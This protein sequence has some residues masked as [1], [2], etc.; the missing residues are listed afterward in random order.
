MLIAIVTFVDLAYQTVPLTTA[1]TVTEQSTVELVS[2]SP[3][4]EVQILTYTNTELGT[5][6]YVPPQLCFNQSSCYPTGPTVTALVTNML[7]YDSTI[8]IQETKTF[9]SSVIATISATENSTSLAP[10]YSTLGLGHAA[11]GALAVTVI[12]ILILLI[13][14]TGVR[15][16]FHKP[17]Q[18]ATSLNV[19]VSCVSCGHQ[20]LPG[21]RFC[22]NCGAEQGKSAAQ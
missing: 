19:P 5:L 7:V 13:I 14:L 6:T 12:G 4:Q 11:F 2:Y 21:S 20:L 17:K 1:H 9:T 16:V 18:P 8:Q 10:E 3:Y 15:A 22:N